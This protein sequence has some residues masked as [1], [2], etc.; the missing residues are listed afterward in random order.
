MNVVEVGEI[1][2]LSDNKKYSVVY[3]NVLNYKNYIYLIDKDDY[4]NTMFCEYDSN[5]GLEEVVEP[6][7]IE[8][9][10]LKFSKDMN[11]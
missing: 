4:T 5:D 2:T 3:S 11:Q 10:M 7:I 1:L 8:Q 9:L 6:E